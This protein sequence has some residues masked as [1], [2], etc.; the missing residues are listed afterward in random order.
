M[1]A[2][3]LALAISMMSSSAAFAQGT[4]QAKPQTKDKKEKPADKN[5]KTDSSKAASAPKTE[6]KVIPLQGGQAPAPGNPPA[7]P[8]ADP[9]RG[10]IPGGG[11]A[12]PPTGAPAGPGVQT[13]PGKTI[14]L[15]QNPEGIRFSQGGFGRRDRGGLAPGGTVSMDFRG[16]DINNVLK[17]FSQA[18]GW[19][20]VPHPTLTGN[21]TII[22][23]K[24]LSIDQAFEVLQASLQIRGFTGQFSKVGDTTILKIVPLP[25]ALAG[26]SSIIRTDGRP[27]TSE[28]MKNQVITQVIPIENVDAKTLATELMPLVSKGA[29]IVGSGGTNALIVTDI[30]ANVQR[31]SS[32]VDMLDKAAS[33]SEMKMFALQHA[34]ATD[35]SNVINGLFRQVFNRGRGG[36]GPQGGQPGAQP[37][38]QPGQPVQIGPNGQPMQG[39]GAG[40]GT[41]RAAVVA[42]PDTRTNAIFVVASKEN[43]KRVGDLIAQLDDP[44]A[45]ALKT[46]FRKIQF[47]DAAIIADVVNGVLSGSNPTRAGG[48][49]ANFQ[50]R[51][52]GGGFGGFGGGFGGGQN[53]QAGT[54]QSTDPFAKVVAEQRTNSVIITATEE[55]MAKIDDLIDQL[56]VNVPTETT[57]F[58]IPL[59]NAHAEDVAYILG[60]AFGTG[61]QGN[62]GFGGGF[63]IFGGGFGGQQSNR[64]TGAQNRRL[65]SQNTGGR[66]GRAVR[67]GYEQ[68][69]PTE[70]DVVPGVMTPNGFVPDSNSPSRG[71]FF[72]GG[73]GFG[74]QQQ[75]TPQFGRGSGGQQ[76]SLLQLRQNVGVYADPNTNQLVINTPPENMQAIRDLIKQLDVIPRQV[77]IEVIIA[78]ATLDATTKLGVQFDA[79]GIGRFLG[80]DVTH[81]G[82]SNFPLGNAGNVAQNIASPINPGGNYFVSA[83]SGKFRALVQALGQDSRVKILSTPKVFASNNQQATIQITTDIPYVTSSF[84]G[85]FT[86]GQSLAYDFLPVGVTLEVTPRITMDGQVTIETYAEASEFLGFDVLSSTVDANGRVTT[87]PAPRTSSRITDTTVSVQDGEAVILGGLMRDSKTINVNKIPLLS[88]IPLLGHLFRSTNSNTIKTELMIFLIPHV[89]DGNQSRKA[90]VDQQSTNIRKAFPNLEK[91]QPSLQPAPKENEGAG[92][93]A[94][95][96]NGNKPEATKNEPAKSTTTTQPGPQKT[97]PKFPGDPPQK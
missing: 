22:S 73:G 83:M 59:N 8:G 61:T 64:R 6:F 87:Q 76:R 38:F 49:G 75:P 65:G 52:F 92:P 27:M 32:L 50:Q 60:Q 24:Q 71:Q 34:D 3:A 91:L 63:N 47:A 36:G 51:L 54:V 41:D 30:A 48:S 78:E 15:P 69:G 77:M 90:L 37:G 96:P 16:A 11:Q 84:N 17:F 46:K 58:V 94:N 2:C 18:A 72:F 66:G 93:E 20:I 26:G 23:P 35:V 10:A 43:M 81:G 82:T 33:N 14:T 31:V 53:Q 56:D 28:E 80:S 12:G 68:G 5:Q 1:R 57:T 89:V 40:G 62:Q 29:S 25:D 19:Q 9:S 70:D 97:E 44:D 79:N 67:M 7:I 21:V 4:Y 85:G 95:K 39:G 13:E 88:D 86:G 42:V 45:T 55:K 74:R